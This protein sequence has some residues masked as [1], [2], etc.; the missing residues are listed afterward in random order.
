MQTADGSLNSVERSLE[1]C[2]LNPTRAP[3][4]RDSDLNC[5]VILW[6]DVLGDSRQMELSFPGNTPK[7]IPLMESLSICP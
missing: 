1:L 4:S 6:L 7:M 2:C 5:F 3:N